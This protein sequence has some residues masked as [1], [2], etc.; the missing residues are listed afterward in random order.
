M[1][2]KTTLQ[3]IINELVKAELK[4]ERIIPVKPIA[5]NYN[6]YDNRIFLSKAR[7]YICFGDKIYKNGI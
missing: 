6:L 3:I 4:Q 2:K 7:D 5:E 1:T